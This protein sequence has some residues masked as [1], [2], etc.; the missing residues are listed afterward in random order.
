MSI[1][2]ASI[3]PYVRQFA[4]VR[5][6]L[7]G[8]GVTWLDAKRDAA[9]N[10]FGSNG[11]P[12]AKVEAWKFTN[13]NPLAR[14]VFNNVAVP[15]QTALT[16][17][18]LAP[19]RL[20]PECHLVVFVNGQ[21]RPDLSALDHVPDGTRVVSL[22][23]A[24]Q[25]D[26]HALIAPPSIAADSR[27]R[28]L[29]DLNTAFMND[30]AIVHL[31]R[32]AVLDPVQLLFVAIPNPAPL[33]FQ[34]R[35][36]ICAEA[37]SS[38]TVLETYVGL[39]IGSYWTNVV[40]QIA[41]ASNAVLRHY[42]L[43]A[44]GGSAFHVAA[45]SARLGHQ[46]AYRMFAVSLGAELSRNEFDIDL[47]ATDAT[48]RLAGVTLA[49][50]AQHLDT[51]IRVDHSTLRGTS[52][53]EF[54]SVVA[55]QAHAVFQGRIRVASDAQKT[56]ARQSSRNLLLSAA[57]AADTKPELEILADDVK[58]S[59]GATVGDLDRD[60]LFYLQ[61]RGVDEADARTILIDAFLNELIEGIHRQT[62]RAYFRRACDSWLSKGS[63]P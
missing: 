3:D 18:A 49:R 34:L 54:R 12:T 2:I 19:Y 41:I 40:T 44:E 11:F 29:F 35:N 52:S 51:T 60:A 23:D 53:Q 4:A 33:A 28:S 50:D 58:C 62:A 55:E 36:L 39:G 57:A 48:A 42:K 20:T 46:A 38:A 16:K 14:T 32:G 13:L 56:D 43:Q 30:G 61:S 63:R 37:G 26:L 59:H 27:A 15:S 21:F 1:D 6:L 45:T 24:S 10:R 9:I 17:A 25:D 7:P 5:S 31:G 8:A 22:R 47:A